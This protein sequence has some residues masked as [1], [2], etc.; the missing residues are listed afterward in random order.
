M[1]E[2]KDSAVARDLKKVLDES[3]KFKSLAKDKNIII[4]L[5]K[6]FVLE[7]LS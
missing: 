6:D 7:I 5:G 3:L 1:P 4:R 2:K